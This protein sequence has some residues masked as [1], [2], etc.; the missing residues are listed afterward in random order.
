MVTSAL[1]SVMEQVKKK[2]GF[3]FKKPVIESFALPGP[4]ADN[5]CMVESFL[6]IA[7]A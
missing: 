5:M 3:S 1:M 6:R 4:R 7:G 2:R